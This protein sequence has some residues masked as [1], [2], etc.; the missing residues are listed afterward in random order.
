MIQKRDLHYYC[1]RPY[2]TNPYRFHFN[3]DST[4]ITSYV[5]RLRL[6]VVYATHNAMYVKSTLR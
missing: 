1:E 3:I 2:L 5:L 6:R 4:Y